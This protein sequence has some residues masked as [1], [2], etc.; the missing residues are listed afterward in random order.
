MG[1]F[2]TGL[3]EDFGVEL[4]NDV[5]TILVVDFDL[6]YESLLQ[7]RYHFVKNRVNISFSHSVDTTSEG[8][9]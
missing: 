6:K 3:H 1:L 5:F 8:F 7:Y 4:I 2:H 9:F